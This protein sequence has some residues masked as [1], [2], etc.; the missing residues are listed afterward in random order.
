MY[1]KALSYIGIDESSIFPEF[2]HLMHSL[3]EKFPSMI[4]DCSL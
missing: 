4:G 1:L 2:D 3:N